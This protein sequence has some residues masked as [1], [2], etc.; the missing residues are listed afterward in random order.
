MT[1]GRL[2]RRLLP[3]ER[4]RRGRPV[5][6]PLAADVE[7]A[8]VVHLVAAVGA[9]HLQDGVELLLAVHAGGAGEPAGA[10]GG[11]G[12]GAGLGAGEPARGAAELVVL[13][14]LEAAGDEGLRHG[15]VLIRGLLD[16]P[17]HVDAGGVGG[18]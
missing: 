9:R 14:L 2:N 15:D 17:A 8:V 12:A 18:G 16:H 7:D 4:E 5:G 3:R 6:G 1:T 10:C 13:V 11:D